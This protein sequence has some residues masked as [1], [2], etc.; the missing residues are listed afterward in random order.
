MMIRATSVGMKQMYDNEDEYPLKLHLLNGDDEVELTDK[1][2]SDNDDEVALTM[3]FGLNPHQLS[4]IVSLSTIKLDIRNGQH[5][6]VGM[7][8]F[9]NGENYL[10]LTYFRNFPPLSRIMNGNEAL[11]DDKL[12]EKPLRN[13]AITEGVVNEVR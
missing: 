7:M 12:K 10:E 9:C 6:V 1:E 11:E 4:I 5:V 8:E 2:F 3:E 13:K